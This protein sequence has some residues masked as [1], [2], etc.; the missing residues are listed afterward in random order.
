MLGHFA[1]FGLFGR[2]AVSEN[3]PDGRIIGTAVTSLTPPQTPSLPNDAIGPNLR[4][5]QHAEDSLPCPTATG[6]TT[7]KDEV[8]DAV[9]NNINHNQHHQPQH[10]GYADTVATLASQA[11]NGLC[12]KEKHHKNKKNK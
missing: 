1:S 2:K 11:L 10:D 12:L 6:A 7:T 8:A 4:Q 3:P 5:Q 9:D